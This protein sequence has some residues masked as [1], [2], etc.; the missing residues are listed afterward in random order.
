MPQPVWSGGRLRRTQAL[1]NVR[2]FP[3]RRARVRQGPSA[4]CPGHRH[5]EQTPVAFAL[6]GVVQRGG[7]SERVREMK[8]GTLQRLGRLAAGGHRVGRRLVHG[9][10]SPG[11]VMPQP[12]AMSNRLRHVEGL[13]REAS[14]DSWV[15]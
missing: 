6:P 12:R 14:L 9:G 3:A 1:G 4:L 8:H 10:P 11:G 15:S 7:E 5:R 13:P 2:R